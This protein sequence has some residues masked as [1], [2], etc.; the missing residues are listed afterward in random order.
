MNITSPKTVNEQMQKYGIAPLKKFGQNF[1][2]DG[3]IADK[4]A[5]A[6]IPKMQERK[7]ILALE[8][9][10][11]LGALTQRLL[12]RAQRV[13][14]YEIDAGLVRA[15]GDT[16]AD[17][18]QFHLF[19]QDFLK[20][21]LERDLGE[22]SEGMHIYAAANLPYY[23][24]SHCIMKLLECSLNIERITIMIQKEVA[25]RICAKPGESDY[26]AISAAIA[27]FADAKMLFSV[28]PGCFYPKPDVNSAVMMLE[29]KKHSSE[30]AQSYL[31]VVKGLFAMRRKTVKSNLRQSFSL[32]LEQA[33][34]LLEKA[35]IDSGARAETLGVS[36]FM[37]ICEEIKNIQKNI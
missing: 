5:D 31:E 21:D 20:A 16:F 9:G 28:S 30:E 6:A 24:T 19:H 34:A 14:A 4:I 23:I 10:P 17:R 8:I 26:G 2:V 7:K 25:Q 1:L 32:S 29:V 27:Y 12:D 3:N 35:G 22:L 13:A 33:E 11:G 15:L 36:E 37:S 18:P